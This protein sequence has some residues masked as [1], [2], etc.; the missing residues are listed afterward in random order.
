M[1]SSLSRDVQTLQELLPLLHSQLSN[2]GSNEFPFP[3]YVSA[4]ELKLQTV[5]FDSQF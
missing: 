2:V 3:F 5:E 4:L 1:T